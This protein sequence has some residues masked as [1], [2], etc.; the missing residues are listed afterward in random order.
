MVPKFSL[1]IKQ[2][3]YHKT[4]MKYLPN[5]FNRIPLLTARP[6]VRS[7]SLFPIIYLLLITYVLALQGVHGVYF[8]YHHCFAVLSLIIPINNYMRSLSGVA[9][10]TVL[11]G[12]LPNPSLALASD[13]HLA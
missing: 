12:L 5:P 1:K 8:T 11:V 3:V 10:L 9:G 13:A 2:I 7:L 6:H 4:S